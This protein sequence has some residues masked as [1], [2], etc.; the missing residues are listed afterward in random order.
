MSSMARVTVLGRAR[1]HLVADPQADGEG[2]R[3]KDESPLANASRR[4]TSIAQISAVAR[5]N[6]CKRQQAQRVAHD[7]GQTAR[8]VVAAEFALQASD[9]H[10]EGRHA[11]V[12]LGLATAGGEP[13]QI[14]KASIGCTRS[15]CVGSASDGIDSS[16]N[17]NWNGRQSGS[18]ARSN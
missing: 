4:S 9:R 7:H 6:C 1:R 5:W 11:Q 18:S 10:G 15:G 3:P 14:G 17:A 12:G 13:Q 2:S 8:A 16:R